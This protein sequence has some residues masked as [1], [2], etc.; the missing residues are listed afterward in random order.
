MT[1]DPQ[2]DRPARTAW[3]RHGA[4]IA[5]IAFATLLQELLLMRL[6]SARLLNNYAFLVVSLTMAGFAI[7]GLLLTFL[8]PRLSARF[9]EWQGR[10]MLLHVVTTLAVWV[11]FCRTP[12]PG[13]DEVGPAGVMAVSLGL[14]TVL[15]VPFVLSGLCIGAY[16][17]SPELPASRLYAVD[18]LGSALGCLAA[19]GGLSWI[20]VELTQLAACAGVV[21]VAVVLYRP[22]SRRGWV[23]AGVTAL[24]L[25]GTW[26]GKDT[27]LRIEF[28]RGSML[29]AVEHRIEGA[30]I[31]HIAWDPIARIEVSELSKGLPYGF[32]WPCLVGDDRALYGRITRNFTQNNFAFTLSVPFDGDTSGLGG[33]RRTIYASSYVALGLRTEHPHVLNIGVGGGLD[34]VTA[35]VH[36]A[37]SVTGVEINGTTLDLLQGRYAADYRGFLDDPRVHLVHA[38]GRHYLARTE[39][40]YDVIQLSGVDSYSGSQKAAHVFSETYL[41]TEEA[42]EGF[43]SRLTPGGIVN[44]MRLEHHPPREVLRL[45]TTA[46]AAL[47][48]VGVEQPADHVVV[49]GQHDGAFLGV[50][51]SLSP[52]RPEE[53]A[54]LERWLAG[55]RYMRLFAD[56]VW[57]GA[58]RSMHETYLRAVRGGAGEAW[59]AAYPYVV[60]PATDDWPF[61][62]QF[63]RWGHV[64]GWLS[65]EQPVAPVLPLSVLFLLAVLGALM[66]VTVVVPLWV[67]RRRGLSVDNRRS[68]AGYFA[69]LG[70]AFLLIEIYLMQRLT[71]LLGGPT[72]AVT[73]VLMVM[74]SSAGLGSLWLPRIRGRFPS[75]LSLAGL[76]ALLGAG[77]AAGETSLASL[78]A[79]PL[80]LRIVVATLLVAPMGLLMGT[81]FPMGLEH[82]KRTGPGFAPWAWGINGVFSVLSPVVAVALSATFGQRLA[83]LGALPMYLAAGIVADRL[84]F[85]RRQGPAQE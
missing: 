68:L 36:D 58:P 37:A 32:E 85:S 65:G 60:W 11:T 61:F 38:D 78:V 21:V 4:G 29:H 25:A 28:P 51:V 75:T 12:V 53:V 34:L 69:L 33:L 40:R 17:S 20:G 54:H 31:D 74:L 70:L 18:L 50:L 81:L 8:Q 45:V 19:V 49:L 5:T 77:F 39:E 48:A 24:A 56:P 47:R 15:A 63:A 52:W 71:L 16:L 22:R 80:S 13:V 42:I 72:Y 3:R 10:L 7:G 84:R 66:L 46:V 44:L 67:L 55:M 1:G 64:A 62:F 6:V 35:L 9:G 57:T 76:I 27:L 2:P 82:V 41:Y 79:L 30:R 59:I 83:F 73:V 43:L 23:L 14:S 26:A